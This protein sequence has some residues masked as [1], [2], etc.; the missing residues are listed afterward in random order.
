MRTRDLSRPPWPRPRSSR[1]PPTAPGS[2]P[3]S[4][5]RTRRRVRRPG[6]TMRSWSSIRLCT[7]PRPISRAGIAPRSTAHRPSGPDLPHRMHRGEELLVATRLLELVQQQL[8]GLDGV[9]LGQ[10]LAQEPDLLQLV[11]LEQQL[12]L[13]RAGLLDVDRREDPLVHEAPV[14]MDFHVAGALEL[15]EDHVVHEAAG[16]Y[17][18]GGDDGLRGAIIDVCRWR[19]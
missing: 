17:D 15:F 10:R 13:A 7:T 5:C 3:T 12:L 14:E 4:S 18:G 11:L 2:W 19:V 1:R 9:Q 16:V 6:P 8:H